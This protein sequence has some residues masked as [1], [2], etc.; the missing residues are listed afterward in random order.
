MTRYM[1]K[2]FAPKGIRVN[3]LASGAIATD[4][5]NGAIRDNVQAPAMVTSV[6][7]LGRVGE[8]DDIDKE[9]AA[10]SVKGLTG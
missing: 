10:I 1:A 3:T 8:A 4:F 5:R 2:E 7:T 6:T 9:I